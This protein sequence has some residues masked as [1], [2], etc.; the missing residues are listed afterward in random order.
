[1]T[2][3]NRTPPSDDREVFWAVPGSNGKYEVSNFGRVWSTIGQGRFLRPGV[4]GAGHE[5]VSVAHRRRP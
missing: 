5:N 4:D 2:S 3:G 1:M